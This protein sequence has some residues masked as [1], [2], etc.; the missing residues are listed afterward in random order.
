MTPTPQ[1]RGG[2]EEKLKGMEMDILQNK[3]HSSLAVASRGKGVKG[4][5]L[6]KLNV[7]LYV[8]NS[9][10]LSRKIQFGGN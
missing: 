8:S 9:G 2:K 10:T 3:Q 4:G 5:D 7:F 1:G 6:K